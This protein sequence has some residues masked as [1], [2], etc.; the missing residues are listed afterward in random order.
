MTLKNELR[1]ERDRYIQENPCFM[2][3]GFSFVCPDVTIEELCSQAMYIQIPLDMSL[4][5]I[6]TE[7]RDFLISFHLFYPNL[8]LVNV[9][10]VFN[11][12]VMFFFYKLL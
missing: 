6:K 3:T 4:F 10:V 7:L 1:M 8:L 5:G 9:S 12:L 2:M 11:V